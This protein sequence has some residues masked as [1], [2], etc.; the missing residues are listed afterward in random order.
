MTFLNKKEEV[1]NI[2]LT[3]YGK[4]LLSLGQLKPEYYTFLDDNIIYDSQYA[5]I[6]EEQQND[7]H[8]RIK[9]S[10]QLTVQYVFH[11]IETEINNANKLIQNNEKQNFIFDKN[12]QKKIQ[13]TIEK[14]YALS[15]PL[16]T[17]SLE[18][19]S[20]PAW[21]I[22][23]LKGSLS[24][25]VQ[26][27]FSDQ[28]TLKIPSLTFDPVEFKTYSENVADSTTEQL[29]GSL[30]QNDQESENIGTS[31]TDF[32]VSKFSDGSFINV[33]EDSLVLEI[34]ELNTLFENE[35]FEIEVFKVETEEKSGNTLE[36]LIPLKFGK[37]K[38][39]Y[40]VNNILLNE[41]EIQKMNKE[42]SDLTQTNVEY[43]FEVFVDDEVDNNIICKNANNKQENVLSGRNVN[44]EDN[45]IA[46]RKNL[47]SSNVTEEDLKQP[48]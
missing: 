42:D 10:P 19:S 13:P 28:P 29:G 14:N 8:N 21:S 17:I 2:E 37:K 38:K 46:S 25:S 7:I 43:Y 30:L 18:S 36:K 9:E 16:G 35:N 6:S 24:S 41:D 1:I 27:Q 5:G 15:S 31:D 45:V 47:Y 3:S 33:V 23:V 22:N 39:Q 32:L 11:G 4:Y 40:V 26:I 48:C 44:C 20:P 34:D 12:F